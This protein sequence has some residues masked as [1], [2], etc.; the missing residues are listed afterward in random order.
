MASILPFPLR[1]LAEV[2]AV[3]YLLSN[4]KRM[5]SEIVVQAPTTGHAEFDLLLLLSARFNLI[6]T[7]APQVPIVHLHSSYLRPERPITPRKLL[8]KAIGSTATLGGT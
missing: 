4:S 7:E 1:L 3:V 5:K 6:A 2:V 8:A